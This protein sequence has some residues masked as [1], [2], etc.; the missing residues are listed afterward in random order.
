MLGVVKIQRSKSFT[1]KHEIKT[2]FVINVYS[3]TIRIYSSYIFI[4][5]MNLHTRDKYG[6]LRT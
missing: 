3:V 4:G 5:S 1:E 2:G 6:G